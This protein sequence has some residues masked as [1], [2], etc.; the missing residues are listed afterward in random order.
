MINPRINS[1]PIATAIPNCHLP[2]AEMQQTWT[3]SDGDPHLG[4]ADAN[5]SWV[6]SLALYPDAEGN[7]QY[8]WIQVCSEYKHLHFVKIMIFRL[9]WGRSYS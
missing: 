3:A 2:I 4:Q 9:M 1:L 5:S 6:S 8:A 7:D